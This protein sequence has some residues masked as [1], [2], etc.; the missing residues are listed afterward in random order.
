MKTEKHSGNAFTKTPPMRILISTDDPGQG[1]VAE[2]V[3]QISVGLEKM[4]HTVLIS[5]SKPDDYQV[6]EQ[7]R[8]GI[9]H[10]WLDYQTRIDRERLL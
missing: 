5:Q 2:Y 4:G 7:K 10:H 9:E 8:P 1:G 6:L 3:S